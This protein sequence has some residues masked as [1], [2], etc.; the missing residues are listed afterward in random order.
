MPNWGEILNEINTTGSTHDVVRRKYLDELHK[1]TGRN[2]IVYYSGWLQK[3]DLVQQNP[4][5]F[6]VND[7]D[8]NGFM[9]T[10]HNMDRSKGLDL[11]L[12]T[13]GGEVAATESLVDYLRS[14]FGTDI[15]AVIRKFPSP[16]GP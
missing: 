16:L 6:S 8:K 7:G 14:M 3:N 2:V 13:P 12:H 9:A 5:A 10:I 15:R 11:L 1:V 4:S